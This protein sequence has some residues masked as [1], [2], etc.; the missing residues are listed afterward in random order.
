[1]HITSNSSVFIIKA[2]WNTLHIRFKINETLLV[3]PRYMEYFKLLQQAPKITF[4][5]SNV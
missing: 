4:N 1:M 3:L 5:I 2:Y